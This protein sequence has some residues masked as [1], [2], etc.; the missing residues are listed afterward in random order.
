MGPSTISGNA[1]AAN[2]GHSAVDTAASQGAIPQ[3]G[4]TRRIRTAIV[5]ALG[6]AVFGS[7]AAL[8]QTQSGS[9]RT[10]AAVVR[11]A[12]VDASGN[13]RVPANYRATYEFLGS[14]SV[15]ADQGA[16]AKQLHIVYASP[17]A[18]AAYR[19]SG[20][21]PDATV[22]VK[23]VYATST[24]SMTTGTV[25]HEQALQGWFVMIA[26]SRNDHPGNKLW[27]DGWGWSWFDY[28]NTTKTT[29]TDY[30]NDCMGCHVPA[31]STDFIYVD[32][33]PS[34]KRR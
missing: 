22:L 14:W 6:L 4:S 5:A 31:T 9:T 8:A 2:G 32:G 13:I 29:T 7:I 10:P 30:H 27:G 33:Y 25:S 15:A 11:N 21:F 18:V 28:G 19:K 16:G 23:E 12:A 1:A 20:R 17:G 26:D 3:Q 24:E 34:L